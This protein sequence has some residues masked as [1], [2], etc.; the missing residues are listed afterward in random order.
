MEIKLYSYWRS[1]S[2]YRVRIALSL[3]KIPYDYISVHLLR[4]GGEQLKPE[5][6]KLN[7]KGEVPVL[8]SPELSVSQSMAILHYLEDSFPY[9]SLLSK[10]PIRKA[11]TLELC[12]IINSGIQPLQNLSLL[13][14]LERDFSWN[15]EAKPRWIREVIEKGFRALEPLLQKSAQDFCMGPDPSFADCFLI[16]QVYNAYR[17]KL[18]MQEFPTISKI[19][20]HCLSLEAFQAASPEKQPDAESA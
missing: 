4:D 9:P 16:P 15:A 2:A 1:S 18:S 7:P 6:L 17:F 20:E 3:K 12:E 10:D 13:Q 5:Y 8:V 19:Y 11:K 14:K